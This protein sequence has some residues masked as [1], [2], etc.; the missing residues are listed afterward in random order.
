MRSP[1]LNLGDITM[2]NMVKM[3]MW[4]ALVCMIVTGLCGAAHC[5][6]APGADGQVFHR[7][8]DFMYGLVIAAPVGMATKPWIG[9]LAAEGAG[10]ANE[11]RYGSHFN[12]KHLAVIN[13]GAIA[14]WELA[15][16]EKRS[17]RRAKAKY[18]Y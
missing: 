13:V 17:A 1:D 2:G 11:A 3:L 9:L 15:R 18:G 16:L 6:T 12:V 5:Q 8:N 4:A 10:V 14:G 7:A